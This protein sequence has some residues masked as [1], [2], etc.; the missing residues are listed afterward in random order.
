MDWGA[1]WGVVMD[2]YW[3]EEVMGAWVM[4]AVK[5]GTGFGVEIGTVPMPCVRVSRIVM[6]KWA[7]D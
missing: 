1:Y 5:R 7:W 4:S 6:R 2:R 3:C